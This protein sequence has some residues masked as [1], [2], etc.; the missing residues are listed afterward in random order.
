M[1][2]RLAPTYANLFMTNLE[3]KLISQY[4]QKPTA[5]LRYIDDIFFM[6]D[7]GKENLNKWL[8]SGMPDF[9]GSVEIRGF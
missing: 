1:G 7:H 3:E 6:W 2:I 9:W 5:W 8:K 4:D